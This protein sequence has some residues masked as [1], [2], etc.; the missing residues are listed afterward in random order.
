LIQLI[1]LAIAHHLKEECTPSVFKA[2]I[3]RRKLQSPTR[4]ILA[5]RY[6]HSNRY[7]LQVY[8]IH[9]NLPFAVV[10][11]RTSDVLYCGRDPDL[12]FADPKSMFE[13]EKRYAIYLNY[14]IKSFERT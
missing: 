7:E 14:L 12:D 6:R 13:V 11:T 5:V 10:N 8:I 1:Q 3:R 9:N 4:I 2:R